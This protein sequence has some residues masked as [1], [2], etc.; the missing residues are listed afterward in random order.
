[1]RWFQRIRE[2]G[3]RLAI[4]AIFDTGEMQVSSF[5]D[6]QNAALQTYPQLAAL[7]HPDNFVVI[8]EPTT[9]SARMN[10]STTVQDWHN[11]ILAVTPLIK[12]ASPHTRVGAGAYQGTTTPNLSQQEAQ[13]FQDF[14]TNIPTCSASNVSSG[15]L[16]FVTMDIYNSD[17]FSQYQSWAQLAHQ[18]G[19]GVYIEE[20]WASTDVPYPLPSAAINPN[21]GYLKTSLT[22]LAVQLGN[23]GPASSVF[24]ALD[25]TW[26]QDM[27]LFCFR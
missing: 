13:F 2:L 24:Q 14:V 9:A 16:D 6:F 27:A 12:K 3:M 10:I 11:F 4:N 1:M 18:S 22:Q 7:Y 15:C 20:T 5:Q 25:A 23:P 8:H 17:T 26:L 21:T 19:K